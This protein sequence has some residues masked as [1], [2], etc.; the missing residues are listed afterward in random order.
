MSHVQ[1]N[2]LQK[3]S[4]AAPCMFQCHSIL[5]LVP[6]LLLIPVVSCRS[7]FQCHPILLLIQKSPHALFSCCHPMTFKVSML[8]HAPPYSLL[9]FISLSSD[10]AAL[11]L[12]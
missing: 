10:F 8:S 4:H 7:L 11:V 2:L 1:S 9:M 6:M 3:S 12:L 5:L